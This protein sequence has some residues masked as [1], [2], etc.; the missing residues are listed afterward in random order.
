M[1]LFRR[2]DMDMTTGSIWKPLVTF[3]IPMAIGLLFQQLYNTVDSIVVGRYVST[4]ALAAVGG[5][6]SI[7]N[8]LVGLCAGLS[9]GAS[10]VISQ[11][12]GAKDDGQLSRAVQT[13]VCVAFLLGL[14]ITAA[15]N[16]IV[17]PMLRFMNV[18]EDVFPAAK[19]YL[20]I[21]F[22]G[23]LGLVIYN[24][25]SGILRAVGDSTRPLLFLIFSATLNVIFD[26][27]FV[28]GLGLGV[29][30]VGYATILSQF[31][32]AL[33]ALFTLT[34]TKGAYAIRWK[35][36]RIDREETSAI[37]RIGLPSA[38]QQGITAFSN[39]FVMSYVYAFGSAVMA[40]YSSYNKLDAY[41][42]VP[43]QAIA[44]AST[45]FTGQNFGAGDMPRTRRGVRTAV[46]MCIGCTVVLSSCLM[47]MAEPAVRLFTSDP[48]VVSFGKLFIRRISPFYV[49]ICFNQVLAG[50]LR[51]I[52][53]ARAPMFIM[54]SSFV[55]FRQIYLYV[56]KLLG[57]SFFFVSICY[58][59]GWIL[60][61][62]LMILYYRRSVLG[63]RPEARAGTPAPEN[64]ADKG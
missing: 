29:A 3:A 18:P 14:F 52:G 35:M 46:L 25:G 23:A 44:M 63:R 16:L 57:N 17:T 20:T 50:A 59:V 64:T 7:I 28:L 61:S 62:T 53:N 48:E 21:Y 60:C 58:P 12:Y 11:H 42:L 32:S 10:V 4:Q 19:E 51:G 47:L 30:G 6:A 56:N 38:I 33:L 43:V 39:V 13:T 26:L 37:L 8:M 55:V 27:V 49:L 31:L 40:G 5:T 45:T 41:I 36:L 54:L 24:M 1:R 34:R 15:G 2:G 22:S 9:T